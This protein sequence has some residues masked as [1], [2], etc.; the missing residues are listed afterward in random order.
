M[1]DARHKRISR[2]VR[3]AAAA[4]TLTVTL[5][6]AAWGQYR[7]D[8]T[9]AGPPVAVPN[10]VIV[11][12]GNAQ[13]PVDLEFTRWDG[14]K[15]KLGELFGHGRPVVLSLVYFSCPT[16]CNQTQDDLINAIRSGPRSLKVGKDYD[17]VVVSIDPDDT[18]ALAAAKRARY[19]TLADRKDDEPGLV[20]LTGTERNIRE[21][22]DAVGF[23]YRRNFGVAADDSAGKFAHSAGVFVCTAGGRLSQTVLGIGWPSDKLHFALVQAADGKIGTGFLETISL[24]C[25]AV[26]MGAHGYESNPWFWAGTGTAGATIVATM[27]FLGVMWRGEWKKRGRAAGAPP[28]TM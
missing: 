4:V 22:A 21:L 14:R 12:R 13:V 2:T 27:A 20:Y 1:R 6:G 26:R 10:P 23:G 18:P 19:L 17:V 5:A 7:M 3:G 24:P 15:V 25:G 16:L 28:A 11:E 9:E 8:R